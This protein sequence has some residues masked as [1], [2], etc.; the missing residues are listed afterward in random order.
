MRWDGVPLNN[1]DWNNPWT[2]CFGMLIDNEHFTE[3]DDHGHL[4]H[5]DSI[6]LLFNAVESDLPFRLPE[7]GDNQEWELVL[8]TRYPRLLEPRPRH[9]TKSLYP[10][11]ARSTALF[12]LIKQDENST[13][14]VHKQ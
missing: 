13:G 12:R 8:D 3:V 4:L 11:E 1:D 6:L 14:A 7:L 9:K 5:D 2:K 10:L